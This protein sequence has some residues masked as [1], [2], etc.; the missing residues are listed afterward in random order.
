[1]EKKTSKITIR[2]DTFQK[3][4]SGDGVLTSQWIIDAVT[5]MCRGG[6]GR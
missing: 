2:S 1:M 5:G 6:G 3:T 4:C